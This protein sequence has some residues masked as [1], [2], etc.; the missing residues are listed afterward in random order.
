MYENFYRFTRKPFQ[1]NPDPAFFFSST[2]HGKAMSYLQ[3]GLHQGEGFVVVT[4]DSGAGKTTVVRSL[5]GELDPE[6]V[7]GATIVSSQ[8][9]ALEMLRA[10]A[11]SFGVPV[12]GSGKPELLFAIEEFLTVV[13]SQGRRCLLVVD[14]AQNLTR[15]A[16]E[17]LRMLSNFQI[18]N[19]ALLQSFLIGQA[20]FRLVLQSPAMRQLRSRVIAACHIG[21]LEA[22]ETRRY[23]EHRL[24]CA[25]SSDALEIRDDAHRGLFEA[26]RGIPRRINSLCDRLLLAGFLAEKRVF[27]A[28]DV[29][30]AVGE[31]DAELP[32]LWA[33]AGLA[34][35]DAAPGGAHPPA[36]EEDDSLESR[37]ARIE[38]ALQRL[39]EETKALAV[40]LRGSPANRSATGESKP[41]RQRRK[42]QVPEIPKPDL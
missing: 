31:F 37:L 28:D 35:A 4:G 17:E 36:A 19:R 23:I 24:A 39:E 12:S 27:G 18:G 32:G 20:E 40:L 2:P 29:A 5:L 3:Y 34:G 33:G 15:Q 16:V 11:A 7:V 21:P 8:L 30:A 26:S 22:A 14:E 41:R 38:A 6:K 13:A 1:L 9:G 42:I 25:G 10:V